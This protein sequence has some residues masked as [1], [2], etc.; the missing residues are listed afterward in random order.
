MWLIFVSV[1]VWMIEVQLSVK[2][3]MIKTFDFPTI[4]ILAMSWKTRPSRSL[5]QAVWTILLAQVRVPG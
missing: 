2:T 1:N 5:I 4:D 3:I